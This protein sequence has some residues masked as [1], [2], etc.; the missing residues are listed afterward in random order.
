[1]Q[2]YIIPREHGIAWVEYIIDPIIMLKTG[3]NIPT[4]SI[5]LSFLFNKYY[6]NIV[7]CTRSI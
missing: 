7:V 2:K 4:N 3:V 6:S 1:M 5:I